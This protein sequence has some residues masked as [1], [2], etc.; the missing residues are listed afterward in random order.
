MDIY[1][2][3]DS[4]MGKLREQMQTDLQL[5]GLT[6]RTQAAYLREVRNLA[7]YFKKSPEELGENEIKEYLLHLIQDKK[8][9]A[10][11]FR[12]YYSGLKFFYKQTLNREWVVEKILC[13]KRR[14]KLPVVLDL[15]EVEALFSATKN[16]KHKAILMLTYSSGLRIS[17][18]TRLKVSDIDSKRM[19]VR[20]ENGKKGKDRYSILSQTALECLRQYWGKYRPKAWLFEGQKKG[21]H[22]STSSIHQI[23]CAAKKRAG[24]RKP[25]SVHTLRHSFATHLI[26][27][28]TSLHHVQ[29]L[30]GHKSPTTTTVYLHVSRH[31]LA[32][33]T[34]PL[35]GHTEKNQLPLKITPNPL[36]E[37]QA[38]IPA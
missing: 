15:S 26:E 20:I 8:V 1:C 34:S 11:T 6:P 31:N 35:D 16:L 13:P 14:E 30:L 25:S 33:V 9:S 3:G 17:E 12:F 36:A 28:G 19:M 2:K 37:I 24:I 22:L 21:S 38:H 18:A 27:A 32:K 29:L 4:I 5:K 10:G 23:F 7:L